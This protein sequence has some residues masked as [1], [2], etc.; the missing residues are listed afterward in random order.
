MLLE[1]FYFFFGLVSLFLVSKFF[2]KKNILIENIKGDNH[3]KFFSFEKK[4]YLGGIFLLLTIFFF[5]FEVDYILIIPFFLIFILGLASDLNIISSPKIRLFYQILIIFILIYLT[6]VVVLNTRIDLIDEL[7]ELNSFKYTFTIFCFLVLINGCN[8]IDGANLVLI[9]YFLIVS[10]CIFILSLS[11]PIVFEFDEFLILII[12]FLILLIFNFYSKILMGD[13][14]AYLVGLLYG[15]F[16][17]ILSNQ[18]IDVSPIY[19]LNLLWYPAFE[20]LFSI[21]R[22]LYTKISVSKADNFHLHHYLYKFLNKKIKYKKSNNSFTG[23]TINIYNLIVLSFSTI[24]SHHSGYLSIILSIN[25]IIY[26]YFY[27]FL[28]KRT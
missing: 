15:Y 17:I 27:N 2:L 8:F 10:F 23:L 12:C 28:K 6:D 5:I 24:V 14:G 1:F 22:K 11:S 19:I 3:K 21:I 4:T 13:G 25:I 26:L 7:L 20:N 18:N 16:G 9:G